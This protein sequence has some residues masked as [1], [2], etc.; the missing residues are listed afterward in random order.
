MPHSCTSSLALT[1]RQFLGGFC[2]CLSLAF[3]PS[4]A[5]TGK[6][7]GG[8]LFSLS[9]QDEIKLGTQS[10][11]K[12]SAQSKI[13]TDQNLKNIVGSVSGRLI[14]AAGPEAQGMPWEYAVFENAEANAFALP[15]G[16]IG[17]NTGI[18]KI[19]ENEHQLATVLGHEIRHVTGHHG[20]QRYS[21]QM[22]TNAGLKL[23]SMAL[24]A[25]GM[26]NADQVISILGAG[27]QVGLILPFGRD[28]ETEAD[29]VGLEY[30]AA[31]GFDPRQSLKFWENMMT[32]AGA[33]RGPSF[34]S[35]HP[36]GT[37]RIANLNAKTNEILARQQK[38]T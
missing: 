17:V 21:Q 25:G 9:P 20:A 14:K 28:Q 12:I 33:G 1:R 32:K 36:S 35:S 11:Q 37:D 7:G 5:A 2:S 30:M 34:L 26:Q 3:L 8:G 31:A 38:K 18:F 23:A 24:G 29:M 10:W 16:K 15:G 27:A 19:A 22:T 13:S 6:N 4:C